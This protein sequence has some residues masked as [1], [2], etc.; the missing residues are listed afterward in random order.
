MSARLL[1]N[2]RTSSLDSFAEISDLRKRLETADMRAERAER[3]ASKLKS[4]DLALR[5]KDDLLI[6]EQVAEILGGVHPHQVRF[7][8][9][10][11]GVKFTTTTNGRCRL[12]RRS[13]VTTLKRRM[14]LESELKA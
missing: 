14:D 8:L 4:E 5:R 6:V 2:D 3:R 1:N 7:L 10:R 13:S 9:D 11:H 12:Y